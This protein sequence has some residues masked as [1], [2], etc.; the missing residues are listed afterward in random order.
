MLV[1]K[2][3]F[4]LPSK[5]IAQQPL[6]KRMAS[7]MLVLESNGSLIDDKFN[8]FTEYLQA[9]DVLVLNDT[10][11][12]PARLYGQKSTGGKLEI[13]IEKIIDD[14]T[15]IALI[16]SS[17]PLKSG[18]TLKLENKI[19]AIVID[20]QEQFYKLEFKTNESIYALLDKYGHIPLPP[21]IE[22]ADEPADKE[23]YQTIYAKNQGA[24][25]A[26]TAGLH[27]DENIFKKLKA[28]GIKVAQVTL[29]VGIGTFQPVRALDTLEHKMHSEW[30]YIS[31]DTCDVINNAKENGN[32]IIAV[33][34]T[35]LRVLE[36][37][38]IDGKVKAFTGD[39]DI[40]ITPGFEFK[41]VDMLLTNFH[42]PKSSLLMLVSALGGLEQIQQ[43]YQHAIE[44][45]YRFFSYG[46][47][48]L[49]KKSKRIIDEI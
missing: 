27:F 3:D 5:L 39:T 22:R 34:T 14:K 44:Q 15:C 11:V 48:M 32:K 10:K 33:G 7:K 1:S 49:I 36:S 45:K 17:K 42:L 19:D 47:A 18:A 23:R 13:L 28:K 41:I 37:V 6:A 46:D 12:I 8:N 4:N 35:S 25:A 21:Y 43:A 31:Q 29:H 16:K 9:D 38:G 24:V 40:F 20:K 2:F 26:P 30:I